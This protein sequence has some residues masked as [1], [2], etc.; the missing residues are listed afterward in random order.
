MI[1]LDVISERGKEMWNAQNVMM[2][3][4]ERERKENRKSDTGDE[5]KSNDGFWQVFYVQ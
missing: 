1:C 4:D 2:G 5:I 3:E